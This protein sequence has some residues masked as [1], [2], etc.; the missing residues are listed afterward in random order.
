ME[1]LYFVFINL[2]QELNVK[3]SSAKGFSLRENRPS[4][5]V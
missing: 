2:Y 4:S 5:S 3:F 1:N